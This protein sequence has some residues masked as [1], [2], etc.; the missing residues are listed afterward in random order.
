[1]SWVK[2][3]SWRWSASGSRARVGNCGSSDP[4]S[5]MPR[6]LGPHELLHVLEQLERREGLGQEVVG[7]GGPT[8]VLGLEVVAGGEH[9]H[10]GVVVAHLPAHVHA[11]YTRHHHVEDDEL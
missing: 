10:P 1:M 4:G 9:Q 2:T 5:A 6:S 7:T 11:I 3:S 8:G